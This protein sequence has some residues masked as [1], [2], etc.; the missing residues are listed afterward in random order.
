[1]TEQNNLPAPVPGSAR[2][3]LR[4]EKVKAKFAEVLGQRAPQF[5]ASIASLIY[6]SP[7][8]NDCE[9]NSVIA[10]AIVAASLD[11]PIDRNLGFATIVP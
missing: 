8:L 2:D 4:I 9:P 5:V 6:L 1:M 10:A 7:K 11:L 3:L